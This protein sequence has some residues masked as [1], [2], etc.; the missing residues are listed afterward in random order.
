MMLNADTPEQGCKED[1]PIPK[2]SC[3]VPW[4]PTPSQLTPPSSPSSS[5]PHYLAREWGG[6]HL[7]QLMER[8]MGWDA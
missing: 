6:P 4:G 5:R 3:P 7:T 8:D 2:P 1:I